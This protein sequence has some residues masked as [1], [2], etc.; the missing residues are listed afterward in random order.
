MNKNMT[1]FYNLRTLAISIMGENEI[2][3]EAFGMDDIED[4]K[5]IYGRLLF[6]LNEYLLRHRKEFELIKDENGNLIPQMREEYKEQARQ[7]L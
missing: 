7:F 1:I 3:F 5:I 4:A 6:P 2:G